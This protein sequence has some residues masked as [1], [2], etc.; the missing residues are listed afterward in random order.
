MSSNFFLF[1]S[2][3]H[4]LFHL[5]VFSSLP[6]LRRCAQR[7]KSTKLVSQT[8][9]S[10]YTANLVAC[11]STVSLCSFTAVSRP[12]SNSIFSS[13]VECPRM[14]RLALSLSPWIS[15][16][17]FLSARSIIVFGD[18]GFFIPLIFFCP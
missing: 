1:A 7:L 13:L 11:A 18:L 17:G 16:L 6:H 4:S 12:P 10:A 9:P 2:S 5:V 8:A 3:L 15:L 14:F